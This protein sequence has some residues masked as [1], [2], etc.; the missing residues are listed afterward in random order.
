MICQLFSISHFTYKCLTWVH[1]WCRHFLYEDEVIAG[2]G[3][4]DE[5]LTHSSYCI[6]NYGL[7]RVHGEEGAGPYCFIEST[8]FDQFFYSMTFKKNRPIFFSMA[9]IFRSKS[10]KMSTQGN[11]PNSANSH[12]HR[13]SRLILCGM[14]RLPVL[15]NFGAIPLPSR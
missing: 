7:H 6:S 11:A 12:L 9:A 5:L 15:T 13:K 3:R 4:F 14:N 1:E 10:A 8:A 2:D